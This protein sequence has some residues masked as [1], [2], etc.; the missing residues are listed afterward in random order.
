[1]QMLG[2]GLSNAASL[3]VSSAFNSPT[4]VNAVPSISGFDSKVPGDPYGKFKVNTNFN[5][6]WK[7]TK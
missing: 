7:P 3:G 2:S 4:N 6:Y 5:Q 1:M